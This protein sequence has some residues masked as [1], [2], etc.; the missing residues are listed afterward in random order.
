M[1]LR[2]KIGI[3]EPLQVK[4]TN[5]MQI[6]LALLS[7]YGLYIGNGGIFVNSVVG[8]LITFV[9]P[10][11]EK[12]YQINLDPLLT[13]WITSAVFFHAVGTLGPYQDFWWWDHFTHSLS[14][15]VV[16][17][18]GYT[19]FRSFDRHSKQMYFPRRFVFIFILMFVMA[20]GVIWELIEFGIS[21]IA[22]IFGTRTVL[23]QHGIEDTMKDLLFDSIGGIFVAL[24]GEAYLTGLIDQVV[25]KMDDR[26]D[27]VDLR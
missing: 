18:V 14:S 7:L 15:S 9:P 27:T 1:K 3:S 19:A 17:A 5:F 11:L 2:D 22:D 4:I 20:F 26:I 10:I 6:S 21:G 13:L 16:A 23:T 8:F 24:F 12:D 25:D